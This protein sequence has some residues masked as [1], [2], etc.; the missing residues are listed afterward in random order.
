MRQPRDPSLTAEAARY[1]LR[2]H[3]EDCALFDDRRAS[4][5]HGFPTEEHRRTMAERSGELVFC[6]DFEL[7]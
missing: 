2:M 6:K 5:A 3:C 4:C 1:A 7:G